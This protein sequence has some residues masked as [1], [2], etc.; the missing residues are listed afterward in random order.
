ME[1]FK[2]NQD[3]I[4]HNKDEN[5]KTACLKF[6][7]LRLPA[8]RHRRPHLGGDLVDLATY[9][10]EVGVHLRLVHLIRLRQSEQCYPPEY[11][12]RDSIEA[13]PHVG[14]APQQDAELERVHQVLNQEQPAQLCERGV[15]V[16]GGGGRQR[17]RALRRHADVALQQPFEWMAIVS[18]LHSL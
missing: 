9:E 18:L 17:L 5:S 11:D 2:K 16:R 1:C 6:Y 12:E 14:Q 8:Q 3:S 15:E 4:K 13:G 7:A 10:L